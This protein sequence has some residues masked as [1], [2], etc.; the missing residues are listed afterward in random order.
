MGPW[1]IR[2]LTPDFG[3]E[4]VWE[5]PGEGDKE[6]FSRLVELICAT[7]P[8]RG[9]TGLPRLL[10]ALRWKLGA[11]LGWDDEDG[12]LDARVPSLRERLPED[13]RD[14]DPP[15]FATLPFRSLYLTDDEF[16]AEIANR[17]MHGVMHLGWVPGPAGSGRCRAQM[18]VL[19]KPNGW[20]GKAYMSAIRPARHLVVYPT[21]M[22]QGRALWAGME[23]TAA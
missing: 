22:R 23:R 19:V 12:G 16:A 14:T 17:T 4:D 21:M 6:D 5:L 2:D 1:R 8:E 11:L 15:A 13:L 3:L 7:D 9:A 10:W 18:T 20:T